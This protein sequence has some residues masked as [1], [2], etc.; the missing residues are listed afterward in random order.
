MSDRSGDDVAVL[1]G[2]SGPAHPDNAGMEAV[3]RISELLARLRDLDIGVRLDGD[4]LIVAS[5]EGGPSEE[6]RAELE[7]LNVGLVDYLRNQ[8]PDVLGFGRIKPLSANGFSDSLTVGGAE[9]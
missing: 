3:R 9:W 5:P 8:E 6:T 1:D 7:S 4:R 2:G